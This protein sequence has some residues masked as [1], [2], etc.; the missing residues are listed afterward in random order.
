MSRCLITGCG[1]F[2]EANGNRYHGDLH[3]EG[4]CYIFHCNQLNPN[5]RAKALG[6]DSKEESRTVFISAHHNYFTRW[7]VFVLLKEKCRL[8]AGAADYLRP[9][10]LYADD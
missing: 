9:K 4:D 8:N 5:N 6:P 7:G 10:R 2:D 3:E 1:L